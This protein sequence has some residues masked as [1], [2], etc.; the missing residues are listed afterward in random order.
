MKFMHYITQ[1]K[2]LKLKNIILNDEN[3]TLATQNILLQR[4]SQAYEIEN[5]KSGRKI[6]ALRTERKNLIEALVLQSGNEASGIEGIDKRI[7]EEQQI[8][9]FKPEAGVIKIEK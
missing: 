7:L 2:H 9:T 5:F 6:A 8:M 4:Q 3:G 1:W